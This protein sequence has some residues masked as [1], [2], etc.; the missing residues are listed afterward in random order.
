MCDKNTYVGT[1]TRGGGGP[2]CRILWYKEKQQQNERFPL[3][4]V[5]LVYL[6]HPK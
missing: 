6:L 5:W 4:M 1:Y 2:N 3:L